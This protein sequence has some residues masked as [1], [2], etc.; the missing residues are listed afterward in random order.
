[1]SEYINIAYSLKQLKENILNHRPYRK[2]CSVN[3]LVDLDG[4]E[5]REDL[6]R[7]FETGVEAALASSDK[8][9]FATKEATA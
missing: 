6:F 3:D 4:M 7:K 8:E 1:M 5:T 9:A 2:G